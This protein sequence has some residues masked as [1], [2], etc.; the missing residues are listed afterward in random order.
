L[1]IIPELFA[2]E[3][4]NAFRI[5]VKV[6]LE[7]HVLLA[8]V[9]EVAVEIRQ[10]ILQCVVHAAEGIG[11]H[12][13]GNDAVDRVSHEIDQAHVRMTEWMRPGTLRIAGNFV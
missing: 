3:N 8:A 1:T 9:H 11:V 13:V 7:L 4:E 5:V 10:L 2:D 12:V 6:L